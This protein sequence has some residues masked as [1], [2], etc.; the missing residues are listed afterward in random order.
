VIRDK[1]Y[2]PALDGLRA[3][4]AISVVVGHFGPPFLQSL[5]SYGDGGVIVFFVL[6]GFLITNILLREKEVQRFQLTGAL[7]NFYLRRIL[8]I[9]PLYYA[10]ILICLVLREPQVRAHLVSLLTYNLPGV[11]PSMKDYGALAHF[12]SLFVEE[13]F[14][15]VW[16]L[17]IFVTL[18]T[19]LLRLLIGIG[20]ASLSLKYSAALAGLD[21]RWVFS[22][23]FCCADHLGAGSLLAY[24]M[25]YQPAKLSC[26]N[27][28]FV[29]LLPVCVLSYFRISHHVDAWYSGHLFFGV[30]MHS[31]W[32]VAAVALVAGL[33]D[34]PLA[35]AWVA[36]SPLRFLGRISYGIYV[37]HF[38][39][40][41]LERRLSLGHIASPRLAFGYLALLTLIF[42][43]LS[44]YFFESRFL[45]LK[46]R[47]A[48]RT[49]AR[50]G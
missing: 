30:V 3:L 19:W 17:L 50:T 6:S 36:W 47:F 27:L 42:A 4:A 46:S 11:P 33:V 2:F 32:T 12:W 7:K 24:M 1:N 5:V 13:Q 20:L 21:Y 34:P 8:R 39:V 43:T 25:R 23:V 16:P 44:W 26:R 9:F 37:F 41:F 22:S 45:A 48:R 38:M 49:S 14:Y 40:P 29:A 28:W 10:A 31:A 35:L 15:L 18:P